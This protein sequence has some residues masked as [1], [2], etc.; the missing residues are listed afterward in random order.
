MISID[1]AENQSMFCKLSFGSLMFVLILLSFVVQT[2]FSFQVTSEVAQFATDIY[3]VSLSLNETEAF[4]QFFTSSRES[5]LQA[6]IACIQN[7]LYLS[8][9]ST[10]D[11]FV[12][13]QYATWVFCWAASGL[14][15]AVFVL[16][17]GFGVCCCTFFR[18]CSLYRCFGGYKGST[19]NTKS[20]WLS[21]ISYSVHAAAM[22]LFLAAIA[23]GYVC[24]ADASASATDLAGLLPQALD[25][26]IAA[27]NRSDAALQSLDESP[28]SWI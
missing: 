9:S 26:M 17:F 8:K 16:S 11:N 3:S 4:A 2:A 15:L 23:L 21:V 13:C 24:A 1:Y 19:K 25:A 18:C 27:V 10:V 5:G 6:A 12:A 22:I 14:A 28:G 20:Q 7:D